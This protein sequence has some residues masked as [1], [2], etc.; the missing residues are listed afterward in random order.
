MSFSEVNHAKYSSHFYLSA[1]DSINK[2]V[3]SNFCNK[4]KVKKIFL[5][6]FTNAVS[7]SQESLQSVSGTT[8]TQIEAFLVLYSIR[9]R[10]PLI[11]PNYL[12][13]SKKDYNG[14]SLKLIFSKEDDIY[15]FLTTLFVENL[16]E[17]SSE[18]LSAPYTK[19]DL[20][21]SNILEQKD[22][23]INNSLTVGSFFELEDTFK[24]NGFD[25][26]LKKSELRVR[27]LFETHSFKGLQ[28]SKESIRSVPLFWISC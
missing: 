27:F 17:L 9:L 22:Y 21:C 11:S 15:L 6:L 13:S 19:K 26:K 14:C 16:N 3:F 25:L 2:N 8:E 4:P 20:S 23:V 1:C 5:E 18:D 28:M 24:K 10:R 12:E 7:F